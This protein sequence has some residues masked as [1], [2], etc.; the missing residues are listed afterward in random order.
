MSY[1]ETYIHACISSTVSDHIPR[2]IRASDKQYLGTPPTTGKFHLGSSTPTTGKVS[3]ETPPHAPSTQITRSKFYLR[4]KCRYSSSLV[5]GNFRWKGSYPARPLGKFNSCQEPIH[6]LYLH[7]D[8]D[9][10][11]PSTVGSVERLDRNPG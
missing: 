8:A 4:D 11:K 9:A 3:L 6:T 2:G 5:A 1:R 10:K 7:A